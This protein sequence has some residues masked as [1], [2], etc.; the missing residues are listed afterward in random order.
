MSN[1]YEHDETGVVTESPHV[2]TLMA[3]KRLKKNIAIQSDVRPPTLYGESEADI[4]F[5]SWGSTRG[6]VIDAISLLKDKGIKANLY[7]FTWMFP[8]ASQHVKEMLGKAKRIIDVEQNATGQLAS[9]IREHTSIEITEKLLKYDGRVFFPE[10]IV[11]ACLSDQ[12]IGRS[13]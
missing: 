4:T 6:P 11:D 8:F 5:V 1:S 7:H 3:N 13:I 2:R 10:E 12:A 9:L